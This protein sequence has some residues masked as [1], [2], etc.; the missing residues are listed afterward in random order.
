[1]TLRPDGRCELVAGELRMM[2]PSG[3]RHGDIVGRLHVLLGRY[4]VDRGLGMIFGAET[5]FLLSRD[6]DTVRAPDLAFIAKENIPSSGLDGAFWPEAPDLVIVVLSPGDKK[7]DV[8]EKTEAWIT[9]GADE[10]WILDPQARSVGIHHSSGEVQVKS[11]ADYL[12]GSG[13]L[14]GFRCVV[15]DIFAPPV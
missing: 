3:W 6:P 8:E 7:R 15:A 13:A 4:I 1:M 12:E 5:G 10:V 11:G 2:S 14:K 9:G